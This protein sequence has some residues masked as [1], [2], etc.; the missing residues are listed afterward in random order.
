MT[1]FYTVMQ[2][3]LNFT[4]D[5]EKHLQYLRQYSQALPVKIDQLEKNQFE[6]QLMVKGI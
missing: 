5:E 3:L 4:Q 2:Y 6:Y 1:L